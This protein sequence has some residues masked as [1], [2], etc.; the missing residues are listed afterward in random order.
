MNQV[1]L[2]RFCSILIHQNLKRFLLILYIVS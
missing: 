1:Y 2:H